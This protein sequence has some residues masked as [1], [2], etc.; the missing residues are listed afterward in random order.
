MKKLLVMT[1]IMFGVAFAA[2]AH[3]E[4]NKTETKAKTAVESKKAVVVEQRANNLSDQ[5]IRDLRLNN[6]QSNKLRQVNLD[7]IA[8]INAVEKEF[9]GN[10]EA[11]DQKCKSISAE[12]DQ[13]LERVLSTVQ[14]NNYFGSR[15]AYNKVDKEFVAN[16]NKEQL[17]S[18]VA[19]ASGAATNNAVASIK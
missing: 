19:S 9:A 6:Y 3:G 1:C 13:Q 17:N 16:L 12:R 18:A 7:M 2:A 8:K 4:D 10:Q 5:M 11:I 14:Y 15:K